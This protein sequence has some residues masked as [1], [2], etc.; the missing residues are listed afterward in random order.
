MP[1]LAQAQSLQGRAEKAG[2]FTV[3]GRPERVE[4]MLRRLDVGGADAMGELLF[5]V[6]ELARARDVDAEES[7]RMAIRRF[8]EE[9]TEQERR[10]RSEESA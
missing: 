6:V 8:R 1:S 4:A 10:L 2:L 9:V 7:L 5:A 3:D